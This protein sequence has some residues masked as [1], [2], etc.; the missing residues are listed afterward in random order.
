MKLIAA[1]LAAGF[2]LSMSLPVIAADQAA[3]GKP[4]QLAQKTDQ[5][6]KTKASKTKTK[7]SK[8]KDNTRS[9]KGGA[10][11]G[12]ERSDQVQGMKKSKQ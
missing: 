12:D 10:M 1:A 6:T 8:S 3:S 5:D 4:V 9:N 11:R 2:V 7:A